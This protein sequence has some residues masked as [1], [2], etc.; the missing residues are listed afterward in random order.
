MYVIIYVLYIIFIINKTK[1]IL[2]IIRSLFLYISTYLYNKAV[3]F[4]FLKSF[5]IRFVPIYLN[6]SNQ[7]TL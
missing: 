3:S 6:D 4:R 5:D 2:F 7:I 1:K